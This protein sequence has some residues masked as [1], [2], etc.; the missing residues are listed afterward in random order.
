MGILYFLSK[1]RL[2]DEYEGLPLQQLFSGDGVAVLGQQRD[3][4]LGD[5]I[6]QLLGSSITETSTAQHNLK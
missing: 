2:S 6:L 1:L 5:I 3:E 4:I